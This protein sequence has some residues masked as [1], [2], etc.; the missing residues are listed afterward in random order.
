M[1]GSEEPENILF[2][3]EMCCYLDFRQLC[4]ILTRQTSKLF[5]GKIKLQIE[6]RNNLKEKFTFEKRGKYKGT[7]RRKK[8]V[9][10]ETDKKF[11]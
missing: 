1:L 8:L 3:F 10:T 6:S 11:R 7:D 2:A 4:K 9:T 5:T